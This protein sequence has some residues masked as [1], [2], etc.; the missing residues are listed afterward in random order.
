VHLIVGGKN[1]WD[2]FEH[3]SEH[4]SEHCAQCV[5]IGETKHL[6]L[7]AAH[8][9]FIPAIPSASM[10]EAVKYLSENTSPWDIILLSPGCASFDMFQ[11]YEER[12]RKFVEAIAQN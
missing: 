7:Q 12:S 6:F 3:L 9:A 11:D 5:A 10:E 2:P 8:E 4:L 1:K